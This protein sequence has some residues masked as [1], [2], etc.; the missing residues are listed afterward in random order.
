MRDHT[1]GR[2]AQASAAVSYHY[3]PFDQQ[4]LS[5]CRWI[6]TRSTSSLLPCTDCH[7]QLFWAANRIR[8]ASCIK[9]NGRWPSTIAR[10]EECMASPASG[11]DRP[12]SAR[13]SPREATHATRSATRRD[14]GR[15]WMTSAVRR[16]PTAHAQR[17]G[18]SSQVSAIRAIRRDRRARQRSAD[19]SPARA[20]SGRHEGLLMRPCFL[21][22]LPASF[23]ISASTKRASLGF[24]VSLAP[25]QSSLFIGTL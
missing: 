12:T 22:C 19:S 16:G 13:A 17:S 24:F 9:L 18:P 3:D 23:T 6:L 10:Q 5:T 7:V 11:L 20:R 1:P 21:I 4:T 14:S 2:R 8:Q 15:R 25:A